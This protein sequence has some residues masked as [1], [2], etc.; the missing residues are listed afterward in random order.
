MSQDHT[1]VL[2]PRQQGET[3]SKKKRRKKKIIGGKIKETKSWFFETINIIAKPLVR[4]KGKK[5]ITNWAQWLTPVTQRFGRLRWPDHLRS[6][7]WDLPG[8]DGET[9]I[10]TKNT[11]IIWV[12]W[13]M[14]VI[15]SY[16]GGGGRRI[17]WT[18]EAEIAMS[19][20]FTTALQPGWQNKT[21]SQKE[22]KKEL[23]I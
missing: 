20:D 21:L 13:H 5:G 3:L 10:S 7:V 23:P 17:A 19:W 18:G 9:P 16:L 8:Q 11:K 2:Q 6:G 12:W 4:L 15:P 22:K 1:T 14:P